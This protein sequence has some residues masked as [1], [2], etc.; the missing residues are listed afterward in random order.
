V[1][2]G[3]RGWE[4]FMNTLKLANLALRFVLELCLLAALGYWGYAVGGTLAVSILLAV[5][6]VVGTAV[7]WGVLL[8]PKRAVQWPAAAR[9]VLEVALFGL[10]VAALAGTGHPALAAALGVVYVINKGLTL[11]WKQG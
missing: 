1:G 9:L 6:I 5:M 3:V 7:V 8:S 10:A 2:G 4:L 11:G